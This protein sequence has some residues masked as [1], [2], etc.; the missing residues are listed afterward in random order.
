VIAA[1][2][3]VEKVSAA[4]RPYSNCFMKPAVV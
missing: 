1:M 2:Q 4:S 3:M